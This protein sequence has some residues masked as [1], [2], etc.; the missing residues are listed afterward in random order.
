LIP[1]KFTI[2]YKD[3]TEYMPEELNWLYNDIFL[4]TKLDAR[5]Y[6]NHLFSLEQNTPTPSLGNGDPL[7]INNRINFP[8][9]NR[10]DSLSTR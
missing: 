5:G 6:L 10:Q 4:L 7:L 1:L 8:E 2:A 3:W 9:L